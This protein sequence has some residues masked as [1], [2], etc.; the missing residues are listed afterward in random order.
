[1]NTPPSSVS[2]PEGGLPVLSQLA[3]KSD[4][5]ALIV[6]RTGSGKTTL[7]ERLLW[8]YPYVAA[9]DVKR[10]MFWRGFERHATLASLQRSEHSH[11]IY[12]PGI[13]E[14]DDEE[15][16]DAFFRWC[17]ERENTMVYVDEAMMLTNGDDM[18]RWYKAVV[19]LGR[20]PK[21]GCISSTQ[22]PKKIPQV[23]LSEV[24]C[25]FQFTLQLEGDRERVE[26]VAQVILPVRLAD[27]AFAYARPGGGEAGVYRLTVEG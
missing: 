25:I 6:G 13:E 12:A 10:R 23:L 3:P 21:V 22:R 11:L 1:M 9:F 14:F 4:E 27:H 2:A 26:E 7:A 8:H 18:P 17:Y 20:E 24:D 16:I 5:R 19:T 15:A